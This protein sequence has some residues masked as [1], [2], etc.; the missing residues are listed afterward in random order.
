M[1]SECRKPLC[2]GY[3]IIQIS[4]WSSITNHPPFSKKITPMFI[5][6]SLVTEQPTGA[7]LLSPQPGQTSYLFLVDFITGLFRVIT[8]PL[9]RK[10]D[11]PS[12][13]EKACEIPS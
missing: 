6:S 9:R 13:G 2:Q 11:A 7:S 8:E 5:K 4:A 1:Q 3:L 10:Y 12:C